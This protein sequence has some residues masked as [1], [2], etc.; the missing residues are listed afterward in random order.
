MLLTFHND[1]RPASSLALCASILLIALALTESVSALLNVRQ[2]QLLEL[3]ASGGQI[4]PAL[5][6]AQ[7]FRQRLLAGLG[8]GLGIAAGVLFLIW[9]YRANRN[10]HCL[11]AEGMEYSPG[12]SVGWFFVPVA[13]LVMPYNVL[14]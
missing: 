10:A 2:N 14:E 6:E 12:W 3:A 5:A 9:V 8:L 4:P 1:Y 7:D 11:G 13:C